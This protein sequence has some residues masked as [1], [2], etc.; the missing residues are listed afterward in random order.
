M[1]GGYVVRDPDLPAFAGPLPVRPTQHRHCQLEANWRRRRPHHGPDVA[2]AAR[3]SARTASAASTHVARPAPSTGSSAERL[4]NLGD[5]EHRQL[6]QPL[7]VTPPPGD[8]DRLFV[9]EQAGRVR[10]RSGAARPPPSSTSRAW[11]RPRRRAGP[12]LVRVRARL[13]RPAGASSSTTPT[14]AATSSSRSTGARRRPRPRGPRH[15]PR[16]PDHRA[17]PAD[18][19][20]RRPAPVRPRRLPLPST[21]DGGRRNDLHDDAQSLARCWASCCASTSACAGAALPP[22]R[23]IAPGLRTKV[24]GAASACCA[25]AAWWPTRAAARAA[26]RGR[27]A[28]CACGK[29]EYRAAP[30][31]RSRAAANKRVSV[32]VPLGRKARGRAPA[33]RGDTARSGSAGPPCPRRHRQPLEL[34]AGAAQAWSRQALASSARRRSRKARSAGLAASSRARR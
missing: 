9:V 4:G 33:R 6:D 13:R 1:I 26:R 18:E 16:R 17:R 34:V 29:R 23:D 10:L 30:S 7:A 24:Q 3:P 2:G 21:G 12:A 14:P 15:A 19:P 32:K 31:V 8:T 28:G 5:H 25:C 20:Q 27:S 11:S 22:A